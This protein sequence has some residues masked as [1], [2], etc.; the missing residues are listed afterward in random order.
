MTVLRPLVSVLISNGK[1]LLYSL[2]KLSLYIIY[3]FFS[4]SIFEY[5][6]LSIINDKL[7]EIVGVGESLSGEISST[8]DLKKQAVATLSS[9]SANA[10]RNYKGDTNEEEFLKA[11]DKST[12]ISWKAIKP[13]NI[14]SDWTGE[15]TI[16]K[17]G[18]KF[19]IDGITRKDL[20]KITNNTF[21]PYVEK[22]IEDLLRANKIKTGST[23]NKYFTTDPEA[24]TTSYFKTYESNPSIISN[25]FEHHADVENIDGKYHL[26]SYVK[27]PQTNNQFKRIE[28]PFVFDTEEKVSE[29]F[30]SLTPSQLN[31]YIINDK[32]KQKKLK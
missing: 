14:N 31:A 15:V 11:L 29:L 9:Y 7:K 28:I 19:T 24:W 17:D 4:K 21:K 32:I 10:L 23:N 5:P 12:A 1:S 16:L 13:T 18:K 27:T 8:D 26:V 20:E 25:G 6:T 3:V 2:F 30:R 22:P